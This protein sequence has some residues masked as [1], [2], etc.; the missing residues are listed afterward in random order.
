MSVISLQSLLTPEKVVEVDYPG[1]EGFKLKIAFLSREEIVK[2]RKKCTVTKFDKR[3]RQPQDELDEELFL[4]T[5]VNS[6]VK[7]WSGLKF[8]YLQELMLVDLST[9]EDV[10]QELEYNQDNALVLMKNSQ[11]L[12]GFVTDITSNLANFTK[13]SSV[14]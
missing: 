12:D 14:K 8:R 13:Y 2:I 5:Y 7:G 9:V 1:F 3:T 11:E 10:E 6:V 4:K